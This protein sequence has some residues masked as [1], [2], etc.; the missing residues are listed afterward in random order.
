M[1][2]EQKISAPDALSTQSRLVAALRS[3]ACYPHPVDAVEHLETHIS[4]ILLAGEF[5]YK[6]KKPLDLGFLDFSTLEDRRFYCEEEVRLNRRFAPQLYLDVQPIR[7]NIAAPRIGGMNDATGT[8][9]D[10]AVRMRRFPQEALFDT[11]TRNGTLGN[12]HIDSLATVIAGFHATCAHS[13][14]N[15]PWGTAASIAAPMRQNFSQLRQLTQDADELARLDTLEAWSEREHARLTETFEA[16]RRDGRVHECHGDLHL[17]NVVWLNEAAQP[18]DGIEFNAELRWTDVI[19]EIAFMVMDLIRHDRAPLAWRFLN[20]WLT[21]SGDFAG[22]DLL[23]A[24]LVYRAMVRA[25]VACLRG[26]QPDIDAETRHTALADHDRYIALATRFTSTQAP[27]PALIVM[28]GL[29]GTGKSVLAGALCEHIGGIQVR[30]DVERKRLR[31]LAPLARSASD[32][33]SGIYDAQ[34]T[35]DTYAELARLAGTL[36]DAGWPAVIDAAF[37]KRSERELLRE[38]A[39]ARGVPLIFVTCTADDQTLRQRIV[40]REAG[41]RD[42]SEATQEILEKQRHWQEPLDEPAAAG[43]HRLTIDTSLERR[44]TSLAR[45]T[46]ALSAER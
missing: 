15:S 3:P 41:G 8:I 26:A 9:L 11:M 36:L 19:S 1:K 7:G 31:G 17:G 20:G 28:H 32:A 16:R 18:F 30:S 38:L 29:S 37:L 21:H 14:A 12:Q 35:R 27:V 6:L 33:R 45:I 10:H 23:R 2:P 46:D 4:H 43:E 5:A 44:E 34:T 42:A 40:A 39:K 25:K 22:I 24:Y 13:D